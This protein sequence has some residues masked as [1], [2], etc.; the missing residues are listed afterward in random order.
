MTVQAASSTEATSKVLKNGSSLPAS[1]LIMLWIVSSACC[2]EAHATPLLQLDPAQQSYSLD[3]H[4][5]YIED[6]SGQLDIASIRQKSENAWQ[7]HSGPGL[8]FGFS[9]SAYWFRI[10]VE[11]SEPQSWL[12]EINHPLL[13]EITLFLFAGEELL[14]EVQTGDSRPFAERPLKFREFILPLRLPS[15]E[16]ATIYLRVKSSGSVQVPLE[17]W[18]EAAFYEQDEMETAIIGVYFGIILAMILYNLFLYLRVYEAA[19]IYYV[20]YVVMFGLFIAGLSGWGYKYLWPGAVA[21]QQYGLAIFIILGGIFVCRFVHYFLDLPKQ[22]PRIEQ[23]LTGSVL[24]LLFLLCLLPFSSYHMVI[25]PALIMVM[26][27]SMI[28]LYAGILLWRR[29]GVIA[30][31]FT[32]AWSTFLIAVLLAILEKFAFLPTTYWAEIFLPA[33]M[34]LELILLSLALGERINSEKQYRIQAQQEIIQLQTKSQEELEQEVHVRTLALEEANAKLHLLAITDGL[35]GIFNLRHFLEQGT[36]N[37][38]IARRYQRPIALIMLDIDHFKSVNDTYGHDVG[39]EVLKHVVATCC[40]INR[41]TDIIGRL[42][43]EEFGIL[44]LETPAAAAYTVAERLRCEIEASSIDH[45]GEAI[46]VTVSQGVCTIDPTQ[47]YLTIEQMRKVAD[48]ALYQAKESG[49]NRVVVLA[50]NE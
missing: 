33:A 24:I 13:D 25:Q 19:Y 48:T 6:Q 39:D 18:Q 31:Y 14:Q 16:Q 42:G 49:R 50:G 36:H 34:A 4:V 26:T 44:L 23:L 12:L 45:E 10:H 28:A 47:P 17:L 27:I 3:R 5:E 40:R 8:N 37:I 32:V 2:F 29:G 11:A 46:A 21:F 35:T 30:R 20:L 43:G 7:K 41:E 15:T 9:S 38:K 22:A 1:I